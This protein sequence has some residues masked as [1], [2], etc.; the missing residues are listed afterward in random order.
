MVIEVLEGENEPPTAGLKG[1]Q[2]IPRTFMCR[3]MSNL[4]KCHW[5]CG[6]KLRC[7]IDAGESNIHVVIILLQFVHHLME[8]F[9]EIVNS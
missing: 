4:L 9:Q 1:Y 6:V 8:K 5:H 7:A 3:F 2:R